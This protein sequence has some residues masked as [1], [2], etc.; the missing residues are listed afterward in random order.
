MGEWMTLDMSLA[1][2]RAGGQNGNGCGNQLCNLG[3][4]PKMA[5]PAMALPT[6][7]SPY[8]KT[9]QLQAVSKT[10]LG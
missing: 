3:A 10:T 9:N 6:K 1:H 7:R 2:D 8:S 4:G 5:G